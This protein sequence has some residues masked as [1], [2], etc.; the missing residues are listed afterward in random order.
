LSGLR[1]GVPGRF[2]AGL[3]VARFVLVGNRSSVLSIPVE[4][5]RMP[6]SVTRAKDLEEL[7][8]VSGR[9]LTADDPRV[10]EHLAWLR[11]YDDRGSVAAYCV[12]LLERDGRAIRRAVAVGDVE[13]AADLGYDLE[14]LGAAR[15]LR[16]AELEAAERSRPAL[17]SNRRAAE[18]EEMTPAPGWAERPTPPIPGPGVRPVRTDLLDGRRRWSVRVDRGADVHDLVVALVGDIPPDALVTDTSTDVPGVT[19]LAVELV[20]EVGDAR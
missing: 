16:R 2:R 14:A 17:P 8:A 5:T 15:R 11:G 6:E 1:L 7:L 10:A 12:G 19:G 3:V 13:S 4:V 9:G 20:I 18:L